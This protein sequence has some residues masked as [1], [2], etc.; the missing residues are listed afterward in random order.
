MKITSSGSFSIT[1]F[2]PWA[3]CFLCLL[4]WSL[5]F[6]IFY[7]GLISWDFY[8]QWHEMA[9]NIPLSDWHPVF[10]TL[11]MWVLTKIWF[12]PA[13]ISISQIVFFALAVR[14]VVASLI[15]YQVPLSIVIVVAMFF[16]F[17]PLHGFYSVSLWKDM[18][19]SIS[20]LWMTVLLMNIVMLNGKF[21]EK[22]RNMIL[23]FVTLCCL[24]NMRHN[25]ILL[26]FGILLVLLLFSD[27]SIRKILLITSLCFLCFMMAFKGPF[28]S[29]LDVNIRD[30]RVLK[31][32]LPIQ[33]V[34]EILNGDVE[35]SKKEAALLSHILPLDYWKEAYNA[36]SCMSLIFGKNKDGKHYL[37]GEFL[38]N[39]QNYKA[40]L[41]VWVSLALRHPDSIIKY[42]IKST[43]LLWRVNVPYRVFVI[44][45]EDLTEHDLLHGYQK[46]PYLRERVGSVGKKLIDFIKDQKK[47]WFLHRAAI[48]FWSTL[49]SIIVLMLRF[50]DTRILIIVSPFVFQSLSIALFPLV[51]D[52]RFVYPI[53]LT[54]PI[55]AALLFSPF[56]KTERFGKPVSGSPYHCSGI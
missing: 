20:Y 51:Q 23:F 3:S 46:S 24:A 27:R 29:Y 53:I 6:K 49:L 4:T 25:G 45:D 32:H 21:F 39:K 8:I 47:G 17:F 5:Y 14:L 55:F 36:R 44:A 18:G 50:R 26:A 33:Q 1:A 2:I 37:N 56:C 48:Y 19:Y 31:A 41:K 10:H 7:P 16:A 35:L 22:K 43:E 12:S 42:Y 52:T 11:C 30:K 54:A 34:G 40:F 9:G 13:I 15:K 38:K 28:F